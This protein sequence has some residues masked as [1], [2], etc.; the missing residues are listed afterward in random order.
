MLP[1]IGVTMSEIHFAMVSEWME[2]GNINEFVRTHPDTNR[3]ELVGFHSISNC[4]R[5][6]FK[7]IYNFPSLRELL[8]G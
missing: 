1:L 7:L 2:N 5:F 8:G 4:P 3:L 6:G